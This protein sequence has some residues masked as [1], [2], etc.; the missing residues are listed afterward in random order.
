MKNDRERIQRDADDSNLMTDD[1]NRDPISGALGAHPVGTGV[2]AASGGAADAAI[3]SVGGPIGAAVG[4]VA[5]AVAG[6]LAGKGVAEQIDPTVE[7]NYW[8]D[9]YGNRSYNDRSEPYEKYQSAYRT[10]YE[11]FG[12]YPG[13]S[14]EQVESDLQRDYESSRGNSGVSWDR[15][16]Q[17]TRDA[18]NRVKDSFSSDDTNRHAR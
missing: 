7:D 9:A 2:G 14:Y 17:A 16:K 13:L 18:W 12:R 5:G 4:L 1:E 10:G 8:R 6:G 3:G 11:G 15:A